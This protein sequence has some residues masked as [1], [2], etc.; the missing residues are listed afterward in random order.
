MYNWLKTATLA[1]LTFLSTT[2][3]SQK[4]LSLEEA[5]QIATTEAYSIKK[6]NYDA[7]MINE[8]IKAAK[9][10][11]WFPY[12]GGSY[13]VNKDLRQTAAL[14]MGFDWQYGRGAS[15]EYHKNRLESHKVNTTFVEASVERDINIHYFR[16]RTN[17]EMTVAIYESELNDI[18]T[19]IEKT[20]DSIMK[21]A[22][23]KT[24][25]PYR[26]EANNKVKQHKYSYDTNLESLYSLMNVD[27][28]EGEIITATPFEPITTI[29]D[30]E[31]FVSN[32][33]ENARRLH[34]ENIDREIENK[35]LEAAMAL[36]RALPKAGAGWRYLYDDLTNSGDNAAY[37]ELSFPI[38]NKGQ[39][40]RD[41]NKAKIGKQEI[42]DRADYRRRNLNVTVKKE[43]NEWQ[44]SISTIPSQEAINNAEKNYLGFKEVAI[45][46]KDISLDDAMIIAKN[47]A[48][49]ML[50]YYG[51]LE[52]AFTGRIR[53]LENEM[54][55]R[56]T[57]KD[58]D[59]PIYLVGQGI[60]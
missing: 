8:D 54:R 21:I 39:T 50:D 36:G 59:N 30:E 60:E 27:R 17:L 5:K 6:A 10:G 58:F 32:L 11:I 57:H 48:E 12:G 47:L 55:L 15:V 33:Q 9:K 4:Y 26:E 44:E 37:G 29:E 52:D 19:T 22:M 43:F 49:S 13:S 2:V 53:A 24:F 14:S 16:A 45:N 56:Q 38:F 3:F 20:Q 25:I 35:D 23:E 28:P 40:R 1:A 41:I 51:L 31:T 34:F 42:Q 18:E 46:T 7:L